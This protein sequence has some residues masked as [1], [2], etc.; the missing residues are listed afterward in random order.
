MIQRDMPRAPHQF[1]V[2]CQLIE[3]LTSHCRPTAVMRNDAKRTHD[4]GDVNSDSRAR[5]AAAARVNHQDDRGALSL[6]Y[7]NAG[8]CA[9][10]YAV[11]GRCVV[12]TK[13]KP[14]MSKMDRPARHRTSATI[15]DA[16]LWRNR[17]PR[18]LCLQRTLPGADKTQPKPSPAEMQAMYAKFNAWRTEFEAQLTD[19]GGRLGAGR[20][21][22]PQPVP[23]GPLVE[24]KELVGGY[25]VVTATDL[26]EAIRV[27]SG[28]PGLVGPGSGIEIIEIRTP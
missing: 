4:V 26:D 19:M 1:A 20:L 3:G 22:T 6:M 10:D 18:F 17:M 12:L 7:A 28:C 13:C 5:T 21:V 9:S 25:M 15:G 23:D 8:V 16:T 11:Q 14:K 2:E 27:A 24:V